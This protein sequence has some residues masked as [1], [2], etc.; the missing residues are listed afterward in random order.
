M[1]L[2]TWYGKGVEEKEATALVHHAFNNGVTFF[3]TSDAY[4]PHINEILIGK[5]LR[6]QHITSF[7]NIIFPIV[8][9]KQTFQHFLLIRP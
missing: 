6:F 2:S 9:Q 1:G 8:F 5:V 4:G 7:L 3:D